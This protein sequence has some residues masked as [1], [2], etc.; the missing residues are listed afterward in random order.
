M[1]E[2]SLKGQHTIKFL[3]HPIYSSRTT[4]AAHRDIKFVGVLG[5]H[6]DFILSVD[7]RWAMKCIVGFVFFLN[8]PHVLFAK[9]RVE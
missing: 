8:L 6:L 1:E 2:E 9:N 5:G 4:T 7:S 3:Q